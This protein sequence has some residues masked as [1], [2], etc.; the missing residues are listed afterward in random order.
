MFAKI[1]AQ[2]SLLLLA[3]WIIIRL[4]LAEE[5][6][7]GAGDYFYALS[8]LAPCFMLL[9]ANFR[10]YA[11]LDHY[12][13]WASLLGTRASSVGLITLASLPVALLVD[14]LLLVLVFLV[15]T[16][17]F[18]LDTIQAFEIRHGRVPLVYC[19]RVLVRG[20]GRRPLAD[21]LSD[22]LGVPR[23]SR[24]DN[25]HHCHR[26]DGDGRDLYRSAV[27]RTSGFDLIDLFSRASSPGSDCLPSS[28][29]S[30]RRYRGSPS[31][32][33]RERKH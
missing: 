6:V 5:G 17:E 32:I 9:G 8:L 3:Q 11:T 33:S 31:N 22:G 25:G 29:R 19:P 13:D 30:P 14:P 4:L 23:R 10:N 27:A 16:V 15:K 21:R 28:Y 12:G 24:P 7:S 20:R 26:G 18:G 2:S 1:F